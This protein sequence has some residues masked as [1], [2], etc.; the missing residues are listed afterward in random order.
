MKFRTLIYN[1]LLA[2]AMVSCNTEGYHE[3]SSEGY[4][5][6]KVTMDASVDDVAVTKASSTSPEIAVQV[7]AADGKVAFQCDEISAVTEPVKVPTGDYEVIATSG[8]EFG[9]A[10]F[11]SPFYSG[12]AS[13][14]VRAYT[15]SQAK[16]ECELE[17]LMTTVSFSQQIKDNFKY[18]L[19]I[20]NGLGTLNYDSANEDKAG[21]FTATGKLDWVLNLENNDG[22]KFV[23]KDSYT[24]VTSKQHYAFNFSLEDIAEESYGVT[25]FRVILDNSLNETYH[26]PTIWINEDGPSI[27]G[28][29]RHEIYV[30]DSPS[31]VVYNINSTRNYNS[32]VIGHNDSRL[33]DHGLPYSTDIVATGMKGF[34]GNSAVSV[35]ALDNLGVRIDFTSFM[36]SLPIGEY[37]VRIFV[38]NESGL[39]VE[40]NIT[41]VVNSCVRLLSTEPWA[42]FMFVKGEWISSAQPSQLKVQYRLSGSSQWTDFVP[43]VSS[44]LV[45][46]QSNKM[47]K[48]YICG[49]EPSSVYDV[50]IATADELTPSQ[51]AETESVEQL[52]NSDFD[53]WYQNGKVWY[54]Y[55]QDS[56]SPRV[57]DSAN[58]GTT[59]A[60]DSNTIPGTASGE[61][62]KGKSV[63]MTTIW[64]NA[65]G[66]TKLAAGNVYTG[67]YNG[68]VG[69]TG[70]DLDWGAEFTSRPLGFRGYY[71]YDSKSI[72][73]TG[74]GYGDYSGKPDYCQIQVV[75][76]DA[77]QPYFVVPTTFNGVSVNG[78][79]LD[80]KAYVDLQTHS[81]V[82]ARGV[83]NYGD[84]GRS[85]KEITLPLTY[86][87]LTRVPTHV[88]VAFSSSYLGDYFTGGEGATMWA[89]EFEFVY[90][91]MEL[92]ADSREAFFALFK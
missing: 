58:K 83:R 72:N 19:A 38:E 32:I 25:E 11:D 15:V 75:L 34:I 73:R 62:V 43:A 6:L 14:Q 1:V 52:Y 65:L 53:A 20:S 92:P 29:D 54:P 26:V 18:S 69:T 76:Q 88:I 81:S 57:W 30:S 85:F 51:K 71:R 48:A 64:V 40:K 3:P 56:S 2:G 90:D 47:F 49:L 17:A 68:T 55:Y 45:V 78:P 4:I 28:E 63:K 8:S 60:G 66:I 36:D 67:R 16:V 77:G 87:S 9:H 10:A 42:K 61:Y 27:A 84:T 80:R 59:M 33:L 46:D 70:A 21:Y 37:S 91:P 35:E 50:R 39:I 23:V 82:I 12:S 22:E 74:D 41:F 5:D 44:Q 24:G 86:N 79:T 7:V 89:D 31:D 13:I